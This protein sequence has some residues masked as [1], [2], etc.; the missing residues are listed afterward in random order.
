MS[1]AIDRLRGVALTTVVCSLLFTSRAE[2][3]EPAQKTFP[4][5][6]D[7]FAAIV[8]AAR[9]KD[10]QAMLA[11]LGP[12]A[13]DIVS[14]GDPVEDEAMLARFVESYDEAHEIVPGPD[15]TMVLHTGKDRW[16]LPI[17]VVDT[18]D[19]WRFDTEAGEEELLDRRIGRN[20]LS[21]IQTCLAYVDAQR[22]YHDRNPQGDP[23]PAYAQRIASTPGKRDG[24]YWPTADGEPPSPLGELFASA[25]AEGYEKKSDQPIPYHGYYY[26]VLTAQGPHARGGAYDYVVRDKMIGGFALVA[27]PADYANSGV[28]TFVVNHDGTVFQKDLGPDTAKV[29]R[30]MKSFDPDTSWTKVNVEQD[31]PQ[32]SRSS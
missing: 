2:A 14:S 25:R 30:A 10:T 13:D 18:V 29:A 9:A 21:T 24:L 20:E 1:Y 16:P 4:T 12:D 17:P 11:I 3:A 6:E 27:Y 32:A 5:P 15:D 26:R 7:A 8:S 19:G 31:V 22:E 23:L 28:M